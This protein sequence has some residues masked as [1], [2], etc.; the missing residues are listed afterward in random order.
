VVE[1]GVNDGLAEII[2]IRD[3][4]PIGDFVARP[5]GDN[6]KL[7]VFVPV[8]AVNKVAD[9][10]FEAGAGTIGNYSRCSY[11]TEGKGTFLPLEGSRPAVGKK[12][13]FEEVAEVRFEAVVPAE[14]LTDAVS[15]MRKAHPYEVPAFD[16]FKLYDVES[17]FGLGRM[18]RVVP[19]RSLDEIIREIK[20]HTGAKAAGV[21]GRQKRTVRKAAVCAGSCGKII[22]QVIAAGCD[23]YVT[24]ELKHHHALAA[25]EAGVSCLC[26]SHSVSER[27]ILKKL[28]KQL[29]KKLKDVK[30]IISRKDAD[31]FIWKQI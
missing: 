10:V 16:V 22:N 13:K 29:Q 14:R 8:D 11:R 9:A 23:L 4:R 17:T 25:Q 24:G 19:A 28:A 7:V 15:A 12:G 6:F 21:V 5:G 2:G 31:P 18:G 20:K 30:V 27:F 26:L 3:G 1:G